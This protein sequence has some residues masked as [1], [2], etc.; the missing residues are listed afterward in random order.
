M[1]FN[2]TTELVTLWGNEDAR[3]FAHE[4]LYESDQVT[5]INFK[6][7]INDP[8]FSLLEGCL[9]HIPKVHRHRFEYIHKSNGIYYYTGEIDRSKIK[10]ISHGVA[11]I[12]IVV[13]KNNS[14][15]RI[16]KQRKYY[17]CATKNDVCVMNGW[18]IL[19]DEKIKKIIKQ[20]L[21]L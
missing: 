20:T 5:V 7:F 8:L 1:S 15:D 9:P 19:G 2:F 17:P 18:P 12:E 13:L 10:K 21:N 14:Q 11:E 6:L 3:S 4:I 16:S